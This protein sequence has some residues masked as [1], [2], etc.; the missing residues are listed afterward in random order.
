M[1]AA[2]GHRFIVNKKKTKNDDV[3]VSGDSH[4]DHKDF[5][6]GVRWEGGA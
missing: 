5:F 6:F 4:G 1:S 2:I 3:W